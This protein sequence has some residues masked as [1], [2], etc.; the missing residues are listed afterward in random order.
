MFMPGRFLFRSLILAMFFVSTLFLSLPWSDNVFV[1]P[2]ENAAFVFARQFADSG[3]L[4][5]SEPLNL[6]LGGLLHPRSAIGFGAGIVPASFIGFIVV[7]GAVSAVLGSTAMYFV[8]PALAVLALVLGRDLV[9]R[10]FKDERLAD[11]A[12]VLFMIHPAFW[13][14]SGRVMMHNVAFLAFLILGVWLFVAQPRS[15]LMSFGFAG[16]AVGTALAIRTFELPWVILSLAV[17]FMVYRQQLGWRAPVAFAVGV[18]TMLAVLGVINNATYGHPLTTGYTVTYP[19]A[20]PVPAGDTLAAAPEATSPVHWLL[21]FGF[22]ERVIANNVFH[23]GWRLYPWMSVLAVI[24]FIL[25][26]SNR[27]RD[28]AWTA[29]MLLTLAL[30]AWFAIVYGSWKIIDNPD[31][32]IISLGNSH[33]RYWLPLFALGSV[34]AA[35][36]LVFLLGERSVPQRVFV[37]LVLLLATSLSL[38]LVFFGDDGFV[39]SRGAVATFADKRTQILAMTEAEAI[40]IVDRADKY[41]FPDRRV[42]VPLRS[43]VTY[44]ALPALL[45][46]APVYY[47]G[48]TLP[49]QDIEYLNED[50]LVPFGVTIEHVATLSEESLYRFTFVA[51]D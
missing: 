41:L 48:I 30:S 32:S 39:P 5:L 19:Y 4:T 18:A 25:A 20:S 31:P 46:A 2:D 44:Q 50:K 42:V 13:Y 6:E 49:A 21:P 23:Y 22:H 17:F 36:T 15:R 8:T 51:A 27:N 16:L 34:F 1:S 29:L 24:G 7:L 12:A 37:G 10:L 38:Q 3:T 43:E 11:L 33:V 14:Y 26:A 9:F 28:S 45:G 40:I 47:F 35:R